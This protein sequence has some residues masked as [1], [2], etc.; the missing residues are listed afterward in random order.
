MIDILISKGLA[1]LAVCALCGWRMYLTE[2]RSGIGWAIVGLIII[3]GS[4]T[5]SRSWRKKK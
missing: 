5:I 2:E 1:S 4:G 3:W